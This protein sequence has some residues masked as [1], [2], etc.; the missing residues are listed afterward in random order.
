MCP[1][2]KYVALIVRLHGHTK[3]KLVIAKPFKILNNLNLDSVLIL[4]VS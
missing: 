4:R 2:I 3:A 1:L